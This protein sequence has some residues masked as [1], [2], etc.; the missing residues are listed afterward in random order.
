MKPI[1]RTVLLNNKQ[2]ILQTEFDRSIFENISWFNTSF[3]SHKEITASLQDK[4]PYTITIVIESLRLDLRNKKEY[5]KKTRTP[6]MSKYKEFLFKMFFEQYG[7][8][9]G[10]DLYAK[11]LDHYRSTWQQDKKYKTIDDF[12]IGREL[13]SRYKKTILA[14]FKNHEKLFAPRIEISRERYYRV[15]EPFT[16]VDWRTPYDNLFIWEENG[17]KQARRGGSGSSGARETNSIFILGFLE[18]NKHTPVPSFLFV[19]TEKNEL[20][21]LKKFDELCIPNR[22][23]GSNYPACTNKQVNDLKQGSLFM[24]WDPWQRQRIEIIQYD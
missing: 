8:N 7:Q 1:S 5:V 18:L 9:G 10:N 21:F 6:I 4:N 14:R 2:I 22:D 20:K 24:Q 15:P 17:Q 11:W 13:E 16:W 19:Y 3:R 12:I 23:I